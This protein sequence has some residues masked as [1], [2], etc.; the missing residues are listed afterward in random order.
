MKLLFLVLALFMPL[1]SIAQEGSVPQPVLDA[2][3]KDLADMQSIVDKEQR[4]YLYS[5]AYLSANIATLSV[6]RAPL[7]S[8]PTESSAVIATSE[9]GQQFRVLE[10]SRDWIRVEPVSSALPSLSGWVKA[11]ELNL[12]PSYASAQ[13]QDMFFRLANKAQK[14]KD[15][16][17]NNPYILVTGFT[18]EIGVPPSVSIEFAFK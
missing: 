10:R 6:E 4:A 14:I 15:R 7:R 18:I 13:H 12:R 3:A 17:R 2:F 1:Q 8:A 11:R 16:W 9:Q 5:H